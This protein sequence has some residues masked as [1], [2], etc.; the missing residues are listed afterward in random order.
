MA[1]AGGRFRSEE[2]AGRCPEELQDDFLLEGG[3]VDTST[4]AE[5]PA[6]TSASPSPVSVL[7]PVLGDAAIAS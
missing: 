2:L 3:G 6:R 1:H 7:T 5:A 4:T